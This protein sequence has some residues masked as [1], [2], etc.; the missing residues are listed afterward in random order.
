MK[1]EIVLLVS[2]NAIGIFADSMV[3]ISKRTAYREL[4]DIMKRCVGSCTS[5]FGP[6]A[7]QCSA[8]TCYILADGESCC[9]S[10]CFPPD[11]WPIEIFWRWHWLEISS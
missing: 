3:D 1:F 7:V 2:L 9:A 4:N 6:N 8:S 11:N 10:G 5:C